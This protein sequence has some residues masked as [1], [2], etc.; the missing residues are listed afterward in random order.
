M[1]FAHDWFYWAL[2]SA[3]FAALT[4]IF[5]KLGLAGID[6]DFAT[7]VRTWVILVTLTGFV[8]ATGQMAQPIRASGEDLA[9]FGV[10]WARHGGLMG[11]L[12]S[13][14][15]TGRRLKGRAGRQAQCPTRGGLRHP[16]PPRASDGAGMAGHSPGGR[17]GPRPGVQALSRPHPNTLH[18]DPYMISVKLMA[19]YPSQISSLSPSELLIPGTKPSTH[20]SRTI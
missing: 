17:R 5:A 7:L 14:P 20:G 3:V 15:A 4:A 11:V 13:R 2:F 8:W 10:V 18:N 1:V 19:I 9:L 16:V 6:A 12:L